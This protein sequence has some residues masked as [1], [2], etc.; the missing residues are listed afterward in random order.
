MATL[1]K[2]LRSV[3]LAVVLIL[4]IAALS[5]LATLIPQK[6]DPAFYLGRY[7]RL[8][9]RMVIGLRLDDFF[10]SVL[11]LVPVGLFL[12]NLSVCTVDRLARRARAKAKPRYGP[13]LIHLGL[14][15]LIVGALFSVLG[16]REALVYLA[17]GQEILLPGDYALRVLSFTFEQYE[18]GRPKD[19]ISTVRVSRGG[20]TVIPAQRIEVNKPLTVNRVRIYQSSYADQAWAVLV[21]PE[22]KERGLSPGQGFQWEGKLYLFEGLEK[23]AA[24]G[25][26]R[27]IFE[28]WKGHRRTAVIPLQ[29]GQ[30]IGEYSL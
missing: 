3:K 12:V 11:F 6:Q 27:G 21:D 25:E 15:L 24:P 1:Y 26:Q 10:R 22:G 16:R 23:G 2:L 17:E 30:R 4:I 20:A 19:W 7:P 29:P 14:L 5:I 8:P 28:E 18:D 13:D 9:A